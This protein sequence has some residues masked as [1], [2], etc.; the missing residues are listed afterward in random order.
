MT[1][2]INLTTARSNRLS[3][4][5]TCRLCGQVPTNDLTTKLTKGNPID[6]R[7]TPALVRLVRLVRFPVTMVGT[8]VTGVWVAPLERFTI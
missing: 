2:L 8:T 4:R 3:T 1:N 6:K 7:E 5:V